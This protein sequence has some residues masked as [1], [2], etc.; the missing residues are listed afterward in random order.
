VTLESIRIG[1]PDFDVIRAD[2]I[3]QP[4]M[5]DAQ[6]IRNLID[7]ELVI[8]D[9]STLNP[10]AFYE[11]GIRHMVQKPIIHMQLADDKIPFHVSLYRSTR[12]SRARPSDLR[13]AREELRLAITSIIA[14]EYEVDNPV[15][16][17]RG[18]INLEQHATSEQKVLLGQLKSIQERLDSLEQTYDRALSLYRILKTCH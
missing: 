6:I 15:T 8:A 3:S 12:F 1:F 4:E 2:Q 18:Q 16:R 9:L 14:D 11:I 5:I 13:K 17:A 7:A 10:N